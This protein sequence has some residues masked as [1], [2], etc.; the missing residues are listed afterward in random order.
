MNNLGGIAWALLLLLYIGALIVKEQTFDDKC[1]Q[2]CKIWL[3]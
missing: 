2:E 1:G 3:H